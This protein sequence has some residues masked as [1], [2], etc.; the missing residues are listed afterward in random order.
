ML[1]DH[2]LVEDYPAM[3]DEI[4][5]LM[6]I[7]MQ[8]L[9]IAENAEFSTKDQQL[10]KINQSLETLIALNRKKINQDVDNEAYSLVRRNW[11]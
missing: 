3:I 8:I 10:A 2:Y 9:N 6:N 4:D 11:F 7:S 1:K 5:N